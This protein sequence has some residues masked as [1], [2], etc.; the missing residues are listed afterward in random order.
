M[1]QRNIPWIG[2]F[3]DSLFTCLPFLSI[4]NFAFIAIV[5]Y[6]TIQ[7]YL[8]LHAPWMQLWMFLLIL[9]VVVAAMMVVI[10]KFVLG[11][12]WTFRGKQ[13]FG[14]ESEILDELKKVKEKL[15]ELENRKEEK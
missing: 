9:S 5:L 12:L 7:P 6:D 4:I 11:S 10:Y 15:E 1:K 8:L 2:S 13:M 14:F 3:V